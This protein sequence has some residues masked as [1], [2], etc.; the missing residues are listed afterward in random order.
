MEHIRNVKG[1]MYCNGYDMHKRIGIDRT[2]AEN[3]I[4]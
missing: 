2:N 3:A 1:N 4:C